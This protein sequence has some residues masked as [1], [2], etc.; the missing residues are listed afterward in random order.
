MN[1][2]FIIPIFLFLFSCGNIDETQPG[3]ENKDL[4]LIERARINSQS[5]MENLSTEKFPSYFPEK[6]F[7]DREYLE[8]VQFDLS[9]RCNT[10]DGKFEYYD[11]FQEI[12]HEKTDFDKVHFVYY[13]HFECG[14]LTFIWGY[15]LWKTDNYF[16]L[17]TYKIDYQGFPSD[18]IDNIKKRRREEGKPD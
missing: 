10:K 18:I 9:E 7:P 12:Y 6:Y 14:E 8:F 2:K 15:N 16:E 5:L 3:D 17:F 13:G 4:P 11:H 1:N